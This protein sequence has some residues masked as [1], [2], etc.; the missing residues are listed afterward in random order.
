M[1]NCKNPVE[2]RHALSLHMPP[3]RPTAV[4]DEEGI[5]TERSGH[6]GTDSNIYYRPR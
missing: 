4:R 5:S 3:P 2:T 6:D 1:K